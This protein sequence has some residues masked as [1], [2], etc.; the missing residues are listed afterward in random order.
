M[1]KLRR[2]SGAVLI[3]LGLVLIGTQMPIS[4]T[5]MGKSV[6]IQELVDVATPGSTVSV[7]PGIYRET[8]V[9]T[10][11]L[12]LVAQPGAEIRGSDVWAD[13]WSR[14]GNHWIRGTVPEF[15]GS[16]GMCDP[17]AGDS[18]NWQEQVFLD[19]RPLHQVEANPEPG[20]FAVTSDR[21]IVLADDPGNHLV[22]VTTREFWVLGTSNDVTIDGFTM[23]HAA[24]AAQHGAISNFYYPWATGFSNWT[25]QNNTLSHAHGAN[26]SLARGENLKLLHNDISQGGQLGVH[27]SQATGVLLQGNRIYNNHTV[28]FHSGWEAGG[29]KMATQTQ[30]NVIENEIFGNQGPGVWFDIDSRDIA[31]RGNRIHHNLH[32]GIKYELSS[33]AD[34]H[35]NLVWENG[36][37]YAHWGW[38]AGIVVQNS[39]GVHVRDNV[40]AWNGD[41]IS[42]IS[43]NRGEARWNEV[44]DNLVEGNEIFSLATEP[45]FNFA[46][47]WLED[48]DG[49]LAH[50]E[51]NNHGAHNRYYHA[52][53][54][55]AEHVFLWTD[56]HAFTF[57]DLS[58]FSETPGEG[59]GAYIAEHELRHLL[60]ANGLPP[61]FGQE[62]AELHSVGGTFHEFWLRN[63]GLPIFGHAITGEFMTVSPETAQDHITQIFERQRFEHHPDN[64]GTPYEVLIGRLGVS[65]AERRGLMDTAP[66]QPLESNAGQQGCL[67]FTETG[68]NLCGRFLE[69]WSSSGLDM[70][71][72][73]VSFRESLALFGFPISEVFIN[74]ETGL[75]TQYFERAIF[76]HHPESQGTPYEVLL[77]RVG[78]DELLHA[79][80]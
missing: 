60:E 71:D 41:G 62:A 34:I 66:F 75:K 79:G 58:G 63:G 80:R 56:R 30:T 26:V 72:E 23:K 74:P 17:G 35:D 64:V 21:L 55:D 57:D 49:V 29:I 12:T 36:H 32:Q 3:L 43:Q 44:R 47:A 13:G 16:T 5:G 27:G 28:S 7:P 19:G 9:V 39:S 73:G 20:Q 10:K 78:A 46:L 38:G 18:C 69:Y 40:V 11:P 65:A 2:V 76:E 67:F 45:H 77:V 48:W 4:Q 24:T 51:S 31:I 8:V 22:E 61:A 53:P 6:T 70:G 25:I 37:G 50:P 1:L 33:I 59:A 52:N 54:E 14:S 15:S 42:I 68:H